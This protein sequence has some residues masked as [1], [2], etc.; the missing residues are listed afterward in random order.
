MPAWAG[1]RRSTL[2]LYTSALDCFQPNVRRQATFS[3]RDTE[4]VVAL[5][6][7]IRLLI[8]NSTRRHFQRA[9]EACTWI[10]NHHFP[11]TQQTSPPL[12]QITAPTRTQGSPYTPP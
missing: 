10:P 8:E 4:S 1:R 9:S 12:L 2:R 7:N 6:P 5:T 11:K 3:N